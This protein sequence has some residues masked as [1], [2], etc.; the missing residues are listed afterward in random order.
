LKLETLLVDFFNVH[1]RLD[2][3][4]L[5]SFVRNEKS[6]SESESISFTCNKSNIGSPEL[7]KYL[8]EQTGKMKSL[9]DADLAS[10]I[11]SIIQFLNIGRLYYI[12]GLGTLSKSKTGLYEFSEGAPAQEFLFQD[13]APS[14]S[15][16]PRAHIYNG[17]Y[18]EVLQPKKTGFTFSRNLVGLVF[19]L[20]LMLAFWGVYAL[21]NNSK[22]SKEET[23][24]APETTTT[25]TNN[26]STA[27]Q[28]NVDTSS[29]P[30]PENT[31]PAS[32]QNNTGVFRFI[33][34]RAGK[35]RA[36]KRWKMLRDYDLDVS[37]YTKDSV[38][39]EIYFTL[40]A[41]AKDTARIRDSL[42]PKYTPKGKKGYAA[43][44]VK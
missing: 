3:P 14:T 33:V 13:S 40:P 23:T 43:L 44:P 28:Q 31:A 8:S 11:S 10:H 36:M 21:L 12:E 20:I 5:G 18:K 25:P 41:T 15:T 29:A 42:A 37:L 24:K 7:I 16:N 9:A 4:G 38:D 35:E 34:E 26:T 30:K 19:L 27:A 1:H 32:P 2:L 6:Q 17:E 39:F 22:E